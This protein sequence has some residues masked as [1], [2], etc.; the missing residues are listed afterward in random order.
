MLDDLADGVGPGAAVGE[1]DTLGESR[2]AGGVVDGDAGVFVGHRKC[3]GARSCPTQETLVVFDHVR[4][5]GARDQGRELGVRQE[6]FSAAVAQDPRQFGGGEPGI[7]HHQDGA[8]P[9]GGE[10]GLQRHRAIGREDG[11]AI[12]R[13]HA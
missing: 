6:D 2:G 9:H 13:L 5:T 10:V 8:D 4:H 1:H 7:Q 12:A 11:H 3:R